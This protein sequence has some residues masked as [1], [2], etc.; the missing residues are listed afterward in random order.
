M[1]V[2]LYTEPRKIFVFISILQ[3]FVHWLR[4]SLLNLIRF[5]RYYR[6]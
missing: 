1:D 2:G 6:D 4:F 3:F 5:D